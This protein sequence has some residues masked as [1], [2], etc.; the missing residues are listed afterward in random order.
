[1]TARSPHAGLV[2]LEPS[3]YRRGDDPMCAERVRDGMVNGVLHKADSF[4]QVVINWQPA[5][6]A[7]TF[8]SIQPRRWATGRDAVMSATRAGEFFLLECSPVAVIDL[9]AFASGA[10]YELR[11][12]TAWG[13]AGESFSDPPPSGTVTVRIYAYPWN[14][15]GLMGPLRPSRIEHEQPVDHVWEASFDGPTIGYAGAWLTG[16]TRGDGA[17]TTKLVLDRES[18]TWPRDEI[19]VPN[20]E[21]GAETFRRTTLRIGIGVACAVSVG[22]S[23]GKPQLI[24]LLRALHLQAFVGAA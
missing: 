14:D 18:T 8:A 3:L 7:L 21:G 13:A 15:R 12:H 16:A 1:M 4:S 17:Y 24:P 9:P 2:E 22:P 5:D 20:A 19:V 23:G 10:P 6:E 11:L